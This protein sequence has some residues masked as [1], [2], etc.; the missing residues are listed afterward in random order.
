VR[1]PT[2][3]LYGTADAVIARIS[4]DALMARLGPAASLR[5]YDDRPHLVLQSRVRTD[6]DEDILAF[7]D[8]VKQR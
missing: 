7:L 3:V 1:V 4:I 6:V 8:Q 5:V 2:L